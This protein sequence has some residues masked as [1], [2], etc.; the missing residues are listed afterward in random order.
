M[1]IPAGGA[2]GFNG[3]FGTAHQLLKSVAAGFATVF[4]YGHGYPDIIA[5]PVQPGSAVFSDS[6][7]SGLC[8]SNNPEP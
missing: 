2:A 1:M 3:F 5:P 7:G 6:P 4:V 8:G